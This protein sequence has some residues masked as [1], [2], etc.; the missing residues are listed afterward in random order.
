MDAWW[1]TAASLA[2][3]ST[4]PPTARWK[5]FTSYFMC[6]SL[7][8]GNILLLCWS[9]LIPQRLLTGIICWQ[10]RSFAPLTYRAL[11]FPKNDKGR[12]SWTKRFRNPSIVK[13]GL[14]LLRPSYPVVSHA[15][16]VLAFSLPHN[17]SLSTYLPF[18]FLSRVKICRD[19]R[20]FWR[21]LGKK[22]AFLR[23]KQC[24][25]GKKCTITWYILHISLS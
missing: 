19:F 16:L 12:G 7:T 11:F 1:E 24:F 18:V 2:K 13:I 5:T 3:C 9:A 25:L 23:Q 8:R 10:G 20:T 14:T 17:Y 22:S 4:L 21:S 6:I 15:S